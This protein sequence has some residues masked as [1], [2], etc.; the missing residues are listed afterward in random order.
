MRPSYSASHVLAA[1][2]GDL[3]RYTSR[4]EGMPFYFF[5]VILSTPLPVAA[6]RQRSHR[7]RL[8]NPPVRLLLRVDTT[9]Y[10]NIQNHTGIDLSHEPQSQRHADYRN[11][12]GVHNFLFV[13]PGDDVLLL[14]FLQCLPALS[15]HMKTE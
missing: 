5:A 13:Q 8:G 4:H 6:Q 12:V 11:L 7:R 14:P 10:P 1:V 2:S 9:N 15:S 3:A